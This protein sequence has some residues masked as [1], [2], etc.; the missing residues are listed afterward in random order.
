M[1]VSLADIKKSKARK[2]GAIE[3]VASQPR[4]AIAKKFRVAFRDPSISTRAP[5]AHQ[6][7]SPTSGGDDDEVEVITVLPQA[8]PIS[9]PGLIVPVTIPRKPS[10]SI[11]A[12]VKRK[13]KAPMTPTKLEEVP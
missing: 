13:G 4:M 6:L 5:T 2:R 8:V 7:R 1:K 12:E 11:R 10:T 3:G 9:S